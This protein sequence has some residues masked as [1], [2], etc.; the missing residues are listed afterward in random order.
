MVG[1]WLL[2]CYNIRRM[3]EKTKNFLLWCKE[4]GIQQ[5]SLTPEGGITATF[6]NLAMIPDSAK[7]DAQGAARADAVKEL[8]NE[9]QKQERVKEALR[10]FED[11]D[12]PLN[13]D[14]DSD[15]DLYYS[16]GT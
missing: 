10:E 9:I 13:A 1:F 3:D 5:V 16:S 15:S 2:T 6:S 4:Q 7:D 14:E 12:S 8:L 11:P